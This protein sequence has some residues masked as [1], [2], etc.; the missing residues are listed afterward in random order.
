MG[1]PVDLGLYT[2]TYSANKVR[3][4]RCSIVLVL[5]LTDWCSLSSLFGL[6]RLIQRMLS[7]SS[8]V[9]RRWFAHCGM[10]SRFIILVGKPSL[11]SNCC[12][13][14]T[15][16]SPAI[17]FAADPPAYSF[18]LPISK[19]YSSALIRVKRCAFIIALSAEEL[20]RYSLHFA[21]DMS[22]P[23]GS[24][25]RTYRKPMEHVDQTFRSTA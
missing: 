20:P 19:R 24:Q 12:C 10:D 2:R 17:P 1:E 16:M 22:G 5:G 9:L 4:E 3:L 11:S 15:T 25:K 18:S 23:R 21:T 6:L 7:N 13:F 14:I 8:S